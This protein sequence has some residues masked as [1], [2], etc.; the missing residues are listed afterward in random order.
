MQVTLK[1]CF[2]WPITSS[3]VALRLCS[4]RCLFVFFLSIH[5]RCKNVSLIFFALLY[6]LSSKKF[7]ASLWSS[8]WYWFKGSG[9]VSKSFRV[10]VKFNPPTTA[11]VLWVINIDSLQTNSK[12]L[13][14]FSYDVTLN[15]R[16]IQT[17]EL[18]TITGLLC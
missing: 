5:R 10:L 9:S 16:L 7:L 17:R 1:F 4:F 18:I 13:C 6:F 14:S 3:I 11:Q 2:K 8:L 15:L 12:H